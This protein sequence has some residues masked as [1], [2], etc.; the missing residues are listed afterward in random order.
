MLLDYFNTSYV[1]I[2]RIGSMSSSTGSGISIHLML[3]LNTFKY[4]FIF[5][6]FNISIHLML[7][8][9]KIGAEDIQGNKHFNTSYVVIKHV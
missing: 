6:R 2:K 5:I 9:N 1:V 8:L 3:L 4:L 7:L